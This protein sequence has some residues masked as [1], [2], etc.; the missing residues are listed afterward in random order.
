[1]SKSFKMG[2]Q[3]RELITIREL[4]F[5]DLKDKILAFDTSNM[6]YQFLS[7]IRSRDGSLLQDSHSN[8]TSH[9]Q[10]I[11]L[12]ITNLMKKGIKPCFVLDGEFPELKKGEVEKRAAVKKEAE[13][14]YRV[15]EKR[16]DLE[17][18]RK[19]ASMTSRL[20]EDMVEEAEKLLTALGSPVIRAP[21]EAEAQAAFM[22]KKKDA[23]ATVSQDFD[24]LLHGSTQ[25]IRN[26]SITGKRKKASRLNYITLKPEIINL[27]ENLNNLGI[28]QDQLIALAML[29]GTDYNTGGI[30]GIGPKN[31]LKLVKQYRKDFDKL[32]E[33]VKWKEHF[34]FSWE[35]VYYLIKKMPVTTDYSLRWKD[36]D[37]D[38]VVEL[39]C[40]KHDF[41]KERVEETI[42]KLD[43]DRETKHQK[44]LGDFL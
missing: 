39:L 35:E 28:D 24:S 7:S 12:R 40:E 17:Q 37:K 8:V 22:V 30:R 1:M 14:K 4:D 34:D 23:F 42:S 32:F 36:I 15:A 19:Y 18:M 29:I 27:S 6:L 43:K 16:G 3:I 25:L 44:G 13:K 11:L 41:S 31:A 10:G 26:L 21:S 9:L 5:D 33:E 20:T 2:L 38:A